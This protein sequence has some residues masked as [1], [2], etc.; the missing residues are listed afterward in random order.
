MAGKWRHAPPPPQKKKIKINK[1][2]TLDL[3]YGGIWKNTGNETCNRKYISDTLIPWKD[4]SVET[5]I[6]FYF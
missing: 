2:S 1:K 5:A 4:M 6:L 3:F